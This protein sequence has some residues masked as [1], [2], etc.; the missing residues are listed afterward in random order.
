MVSNEELKLVQTKKGRHKHLSCNSLL[1][2]DLLI[3]GLT[4]LPQN[5][6]DIPISDLR[7]CV[8]NI[9]QTRK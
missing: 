4:S 8:A 1:Y 5:Q 2:V 9:T 6:H 7:T 3:T